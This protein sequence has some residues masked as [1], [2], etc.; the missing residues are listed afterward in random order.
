MSISLRVLGDGLGAPS[1]SYDK[2]L[3]DTSRNS[4]QASAAKGSHARPVELTISPASGCVPPMS[5]FPIEVG[6]L[7]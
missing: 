2:Q 1:V 4:W 5:D 6:A 7:F 3:L